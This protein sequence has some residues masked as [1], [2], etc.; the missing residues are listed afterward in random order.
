MAGG[1]TNKKR[2]RE[3]YYNYAKHYQEPFNQYPN[4]YPQG[5]NQYPNQYPLGP[6]QFPNQYPLGP[7]QFPNQF[8]Q[9]PNQYPNQFAQGPFNQ[10]FNPNFYDHNFQYNLTKEGKSKLSYYITVELE[11]Y[12]GTDISTI[13]KY[14][15]KCQSTFERIR[16]SLSDLF[17]YQYRPLEVKDAYGYE[18]EYDAKQKLIEEQEKQK[19][20]QEKQ[21]ARD[22]ERDRER[23]RDRDRERERE[24]ERDRERERRGGKSKSVKKTKR[25]KN[26]TLKR[27]K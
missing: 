22:E 2:P 23:E 19:E 15:I 7:N 26:K 20:N 27:S 25:Y 4:Q 13:K 18:A 3:E 10:G 16:K 5:P 24:R 17:G 8:P 9:R 11:L 14:S 1:E 6:N 12:P 21:K